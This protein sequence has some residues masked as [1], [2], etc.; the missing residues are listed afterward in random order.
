MCQKERTSVCGEQSIDYLNSAHKQDRFREHFKLDGIIEGAFTKKVELSN[1]QVYNTRPL[2]KNELL[3]LEEWALPNLL[4][5]SV[6]K[7]YM[8]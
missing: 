4:V 7:R 2:L 8:E 5:P 3:L 1:I 6:Y